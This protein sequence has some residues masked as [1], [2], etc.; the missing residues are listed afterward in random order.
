MNY[1]STTFLANIADNEYDFIRRQADKKNVA[2]EEYVLMC[3]LAYN[4]PLYISNLASQLRRL[5]Y[6][7]K[8][9]SVL[10]TEDSQHQLIEVQEDIAK[11]LNV[12][13]DRLLENIS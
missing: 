3:V 8:S 7:L 9:I 12:L 4:E 11:I 1:W 13:T 10:T 5:K 2:I 6:Q